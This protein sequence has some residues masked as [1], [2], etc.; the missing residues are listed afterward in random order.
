M[1]LCIYNYTL[2][3]LKQLGQTKNDLGLKEKPEAE[4]FYILLTNQMFQVH[5]DKLE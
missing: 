1:E 3:Q 4:I 5:F 2:I